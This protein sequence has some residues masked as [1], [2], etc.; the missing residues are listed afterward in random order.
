MC[1]VAPLLISDSCTCTNSSSA[2]RFSIWKFLKFTL[3]ETLIT[4][5][6]TAKVYGSS[7]DSNISRK[8][9]NENLWSQR[10]IHALVSIW[11]VSQVALVV[12]N[13]P[14]NVGDIIREENASLIPG[15][16]RS[17]GVRNN[18]LQY[19]LLENPMHRGAWRATV[20]RVAKSWTWLKQ[21]SMHAG[22]WSPNQ[23]QQQHHLRSY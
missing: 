12:K 23:R 17:P 19:S 13:P 11:R 14:A 3:T 20:H 8:Q 16:G 10:N 9:S 18:P 6:I 22:M 5:N 1:N 21:L 2:L 4:L 15:S 7:C